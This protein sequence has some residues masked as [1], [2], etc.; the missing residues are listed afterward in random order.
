[1]CIQIVK[2]LETKYLKCYFINENSKL[3]SLVVIIC[4]MHASETYF[5][6]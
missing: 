6:T 1:M 5:I 3:N 2:L 4:Q